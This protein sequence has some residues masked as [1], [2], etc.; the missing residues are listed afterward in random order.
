MPV[1]EGGVGAVADHQHDAGGEQGYGGERPEPQGEQR[2]QAEH[3]AAGGE[4]D[5]GHHAAQPDERAGRPSYHRMITLRTMQVDGHRGGRGEHGAGPLPPAVGRAAAA[6]EAEDRERRP[7][8]RRRP[9][10][11]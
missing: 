7:P 1:G 2:H 6:D 11:C 9:A 5:A 10:R 8:C 4:A 3:G